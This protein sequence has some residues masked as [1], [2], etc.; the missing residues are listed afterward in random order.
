MWTISLY[1]CV[2]VNDVYIRVDKIDNGCNEERNFRNITEKEDLEIFL[3]R[4]KLRKLF[5]KTFLL[6]T[7]SR[8]TF[9]LIMKS[10]TKT[11][12]TSSALE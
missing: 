6:R 9:L 7:K 11:M 5:R 8:A 3:L 10:E 12:K 1:N 2:L 4:T